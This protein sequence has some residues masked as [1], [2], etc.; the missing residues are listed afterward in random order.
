[1]NRAIIA[2]VPVLDK[3]YIDFFDSHRDSCLFVFGEDTIAEFDYLRKDLRKMKP[4]H[5]V[6]ALRA[7]SLID[8]VE[9]L[10]DSHLE[11]LKR[12]DVYILMPDEDVC[13]EFAARHFPNKPVR[14]EFLGLRYDRKKTLEQKQIE[15]DYETT[16]DALSEGVMAFAENQAKK[17][18]DWWRQIGAV[19]VKQNEVLLWA[20][21]KPTPSHY[22]LLHMGD[23]RSNFKQ[24]QFVEFSNVLHAE[25]A[26]VA[27][28]AKRGIS[29]EGA[30]LYSTTFPCPPCSRFVAH[31]GVKRLFFKEGYAMLDGD[32][33]LRSQ[34][35]QIIQVVE[36][37]IETPA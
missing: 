27:E 33:I 16:F 25:A 12:P 32:E 10:T 4:G 13:R 6:T 17:S 18:M 36:S 21:N 26:I 19:L 15:S 20:I 34:N 7:L 11:V 2:Y 8:I 31:S 3:G 23:P 22:T 14:F 37:K 28:A 30:D 1:M 35:V 29:L 9:I 5:V 24:G